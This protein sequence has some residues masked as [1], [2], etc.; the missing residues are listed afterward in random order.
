MIRALI[1][2]LGVVVTAAVD[3]GE[4]QHVLALRV[5]IHILKVVVVQLVAKA[6]ASGNIT[7]GG[8]RVSESPASRGCGVICI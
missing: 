4:I 2:L 5:E 6:G 7:P 1:Y 8:L 3:T